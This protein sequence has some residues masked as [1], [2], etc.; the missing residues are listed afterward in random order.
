MLLRLY[1]GAATVVC[2]KSKAE[3]S[4]Y[5]SLV[6]YKSVAEVL[7]SGGYGDIIETQKDGDGFV[8]L[9]STDPVKVNM[10]T[11]KLV[12]ITYSDYS[13]YLAKGTA[14]N[15]GAFT[16]IKLLSAYG[17]ETTVKLTSVAN[18]FC[19]LSGECNELS[20]N[21]T[22]NRYYIVMK[23]EY[24]FVMPY[25]VERGTIELKYLLYDFLVVGRVPNVYFKAK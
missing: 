14:I 11:Q 16:G 12:D 18:V 24:S 3:F 19:E 2:E 23:I 21:Q 8:T 20:I 9:V 25:Y 7:N 13:D 4:S 10:L 5:A 22:R 6:F 15:A 1:R 17:K